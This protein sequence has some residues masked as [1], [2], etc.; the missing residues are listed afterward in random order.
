VRERVRLI[1]ETATALIAGFSASLAQPYLI[2]PFKKDTTKGT[3]YSF[4]YKPTM[5]AHTALNQFC[6][7][8]SRLCR[9]IASR[10]ETEIV[11]LK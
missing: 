11:L 7:L 2:V 3:R 8:L 4:G 9:G 5:T 10:G 6:F 1:V